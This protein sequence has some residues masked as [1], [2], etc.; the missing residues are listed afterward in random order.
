[1]RQIRWEASSV[2]NQGAVVSN[3][4]AHRP[5]PDVL[6]VNHESGHEILIVPAGLFASMPGHPDQFIGDASRSLP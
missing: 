4:D 5:P 2:T 6:V 1:M 3:G